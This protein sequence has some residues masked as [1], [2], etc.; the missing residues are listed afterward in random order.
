MGPFE[1]LLLFAAVILGLAI[2]DLAI[3]THRLL[4]AG[5]RVRWDV[6]PLLAAAL[7]FERIVTQWWT[8]YGAKALAAGLTF[9]MFVGVLVSAALLFLMAAAAL[10]DELK[11]GTIDLRAYFSLVRRRFWLLFA[12]QW[13][14]MNAVVS[15]AE[16]K[17]LHAHFDFAS[18]SY[19]IL[20]AAL[21]LAFIPLKWVQIVG[22]C[23]FIL[24]YAS[25]F[26]GRTLA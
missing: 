3:S 9:A 14:L 21:A 1:Y 23:G 15:W 16:I 4:N 10:P 8:W 11:A 26:F 25:V 22:L 5:P 17:I 18:P 19:L 2:S 12:F 13:T 24:L 7:A 6:A 20:P